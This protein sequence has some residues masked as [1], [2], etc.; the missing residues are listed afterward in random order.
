MFDLS[1]NSEI[2]H[3][4][5]SGIHF[6]GIEIGAFLLEL[7]TQE[8]NELPGC[9]F[10]RDIA[11]KYIVR[12]YLHRELA[13][14]GNWEA[15]FT[16]IKPDEMSLCVQSNHAPL[17][18]G[19]EYLNEEF[20]SSIYGKINETVKQKCISSGTDIGR[21]LEQFLPSSTLRGMLVLYF[22]A[23]DTSGETPFCLDF[24][25]EYQENG[26]SRI[27]QLKD[28]GEKLKDDE[29]S[30]YLICSY[31]LPFIESRMWQE[32]G[33]RF[34]QKTRLSAAQAFSFLKNYREIQC[35][36]YKIR[37]DEKLGNGKLPRPQVCVQFNSGASGVRL[38]CSD[39]LEFSI[40]GAIEGAELSDEEITQ[41]ER[42]KDNLIFLKGRW[43]EVEP[44]SFS[45]IIAYWQEKKSLKRK[46]SYFDVLWLK[47]GVNPFR[48]TADSIFFSQENCFFDITDDF[49]VHREDL[50][51]SSPA[52]LGMLLP[53]SILKLR[54]YQ[55]VGVN[56][57]WKITALGFGACLA[58]D[59]GL[60]K[61]IQILA[62]IDLWKREG[63]LQ[64]APVLL[65]MPP[66]LFFNWRAE[67]ERFVPDLRV[68]ILHGSVPW[69]KKR[70]LQNHSDFLN[71]YD[72][73]FTSYGM[74]TI[75]SD[76]E[77][78]SFAAIIADE[79]QT[80]KNPAT[81]QSRAIRKLNGKYRIALTGTPVE[82]RIEDL[83]SIFD[84]INP[85]LL[86][87]LKSFQAFAR[88]LNN[89]YSA[90]RK[91]IKPF[92][93]RRLKT[94]TDIV[95]EL[96]DKIEY[97]HYCRLGK[98]QVNLY[99]AEIDRLR[100]DL[101]QKDN[102]QGIIF[103]ILT[104]LKKICNH[105]DHYL[106]RSEYNV[107]LSGK[108]ETLKQLIEQIVE[109]DEKVLIFTQFREIIAPLKIF[110]E[111]NFKVPAYCLHGGVAI[112][113][114]KELVQKFQSV[115]GSACFILSLKAAGVG[116]NLI[117]ANHVIHFDRGWNPAVEQQASDRAFRI[118]QKK[119]VLVHKL[120]CKGTLEERIDQL[121]ADKM[122]LA[123]D[124][125][126]DGIEKILVD[127]THDELIDFLS[128]SQSNWGFK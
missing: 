20:L 10:F 2:M 48:D 30:I 39:F 108:F 29:D 1:S 26:I 28:L 71:S 59:M 6:N 111:Q 125:L 112:K 77:N 40:F 88:S 95:P 92:I 8:Q 89:D 114:R 50:G 122:K 55:E 101:A 80:I 98:E 123:S 24:L 64:K 12:M 37:L 99:K 57:L 58:D 63:K 120:I 14:D 82:N 5:F 84:F 36:G 60:G 75:L 128:L 107:E 83:W 70:F 105:P 22:S 86:R 115:D 85:G 69:E 76:L 121:M 49:Q 54:H 127:M 16:C 35:L 44:D 117:K 23:P 41:I 68:A 56:F 42:C 51:D 93:L 65:V 116:L 91:L 33:A 81:K 119:N 34:I 61:T 18:H 106:K 79:A 17:I 113:E 97:K 110:I 67:C 104:K 15:L 53:N 11:Q 31:L 78:L 38:K 90:I 45:K 52:Q 27:I 96:P 109:M 46:L 13:K 126:S 73:V 43:I 74:L 9:C 19:R 87:D 66:T 32:I 100:N 102:S 72:L 4:Q 21:Y 94:D 62:L 103:S 124:L 7:I 118:G 47:A 3:V 25:W